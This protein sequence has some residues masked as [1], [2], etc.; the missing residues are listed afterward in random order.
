MNL[1]EVYI[2]EVIRRLPEKSREDISLELRST[3]EDMLPDNYNEDDVKEVLEKLGNP[4]ALASGYRDQPMHLIGPRYYDVYLSLLKLILPIAALVAVLSVAIE[5]FSGVNTRSDIV[6]GVLDL[7]SFG[8]G[9]VLEV[10]VHVFFWIT[11]VFAVTERFDKDKAQTPLTANLKP[12]TADDLKDVPYIPKKKA[13]GTGEVVTAFVWIAI[14]ASLYFYA[15]RLFGI[16]EGGR[17]Q[18]EPQIAAFNQD[19][20]H[21]FWPIAVVVIALEVALA[22]YKFIKKKWT[23]TVAIFNTVVEIVGTAMFTVILLQPQVWNDTFISYLSNKLPLTATGLS[24][25]LIVIALIFTVISI[26]DG[27]RKAKIREERA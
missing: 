18:F 16:Y 4:A 19:I 15:D 13:I 21:A 24:S 10:G 9:R 5:S 1:I 26:M 2:E 8:V 6:M 11:I 27:F 14:W 23:K 3:I 25:G 12:W 20:L 22:V 7:I 17:V